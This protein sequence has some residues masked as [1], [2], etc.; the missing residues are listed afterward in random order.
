MGLD[1]SWTLRQRNFNL[2]SAL[3]EAF[4]Y[5]FGSVMNAIEI[6]DKLYSNLK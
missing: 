4:L 6:D 5:F 2:I 3:C 1:L